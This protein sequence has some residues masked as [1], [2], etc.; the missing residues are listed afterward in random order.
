ML[1]LIKGDAKNLEGKVTICADLLEKENAQ[2]LA[3]FTSTNI[4]DIEKLCYAQLHIPK[5][6]LSESF[7]QL[8]EQ[9]RSKKFTRIDFY[10][11][12]IPEMNEQIQ[13]S[14]IGDMIK[15]GEF[16]DM[17]KLDEHMSVNIWKYAL[18]Y[19]RQNLPN[20]KIEDTDISS[21]GIQCGRRNNLFLN[22]TIIIPF[23]HYTNYQEGDISERLLDDYVQPLQ[24]A[25]SSQNNH[26]T[27]E[28]ILRMQKFLNTKKSES[29]DFQKDIDNLLLHIISGASNGKEVACLYANKLIA[30]SREY[31][32]DAAMIRDR[33]E[34]FSSL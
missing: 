5:D 9:N 3:L 7:N 10:S 12:G 21:Y 20:A 4:K 8:K 31:Y 17:E 23:D 6:A 14:I 33:I 1:K 19:V 29:F 34:Q 30:L 28:L 16:D 15:I 25:L 2:N 24:R 18:K 26:I 27:N 22:R 13:K 11:M 32:E